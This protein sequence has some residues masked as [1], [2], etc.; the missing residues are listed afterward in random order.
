VFGE[1]KDTLELSKAK[2]NDQKRIDEL[3]K[4]LAEIKLNYKNEKKA[5]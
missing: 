3:K 5:M 2:T 1:S 4:H